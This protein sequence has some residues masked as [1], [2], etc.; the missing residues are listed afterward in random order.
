MVQGYE[1]V[2]LWPKFVI[3]SP[4]PHSFYLQ[5]ATNSNLAQSNRLGISILVKINMDCEQLFCNKNKHYD[6]S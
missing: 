3:Y 5:I 4:L 6:Y 2:I 1:N